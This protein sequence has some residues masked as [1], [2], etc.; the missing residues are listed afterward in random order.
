[1]SLK[2]R[3][4]SILT[5]AIASLAFSTFTFAQDSKA[6]TPAPD[7]DKADKHYKGEGRGSGKGHGEG[8]GFG[9]RHGG[10][11]RMLLDLNLSE[12]QKTQIHS[13]MDSNKPDQTTRD[14]MRT[15]YEAKR[16]GTLTAEQQAR[17]DAIK[18][19]S[20]ANAKAVHEQ[21]MNVLTV[22]QKAQ[23]EQKK[24]EMKQRKQERHERYQ[25]EKAPAATAPIL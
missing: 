22:E 1:M 12:A 17:L 10:M 8:K 21:I 24:L 11:M 7:K 2:R 6:T 16:A 13:I 23:L 5:V 14:E 18:E 3:F 19:Q 20:K 9:H 25:K 4:L 15:L